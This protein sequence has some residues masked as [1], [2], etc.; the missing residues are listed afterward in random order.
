MQGVRKKRFKQNSAWSPK[1]KIHIT[2]GPSDFLFEVVASD[3]LTPCKT[4]PKS[5]KLNQKLQKVNPKN[6]FQKFLY[7]SLTGV[8]F[9]LTLV[10]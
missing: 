3:F 6:L 2:G 1:T 9:M 10:S 4:Y 7:F 5:T 8:G